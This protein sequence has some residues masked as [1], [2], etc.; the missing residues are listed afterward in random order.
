MKNLKNVVLVLLMLVLALNL[1]ACGASETQESKPTETPSEATQPVD[2]T[3]AQEATEAPTETTLPEGVVLYT[4]TVQD[5]A[6]NPIAGAMVQLCLDACVPG[7]TDETGV[8]KFAVEEA[9]YKVSFLALPAGYTYATEEE[10]FYFED[11]SKEI[12]LVLKAEG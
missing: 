11:G 6:G 4:V 12:T 5:E 2:T 9:D 10:N 8:A 1:C 3:E 7:V